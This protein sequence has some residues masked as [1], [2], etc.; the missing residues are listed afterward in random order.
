[1][2]R[3]FTW[4]VRSGG[5]HLVLRETPR[6]TLMPQAAPRAGQGDVEGDG[7]VLLKKQKR[8]GKDEFGA[9]AIPLR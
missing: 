6:P 7:N 3:A 4:Y 5:H 8:G 1:M 2:A 9:R